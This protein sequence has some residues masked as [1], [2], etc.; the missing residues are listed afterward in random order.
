MHCLSKYGQMLSIMCTILLKLS[1][2]AT[3]I[4]KLSSTIQATVASSSISWC[5]T[6]GVL[7]WLHHDVLQTVFSCYHNLCWVA[8]WYWS[9]YFMNKMNISSNLKSYYCSLLLFQSAYILQ[10]IFY[11]Y[12]FGGKYYIASA[13]L[14]LNN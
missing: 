14:K 6:L 11:H 7:F 3:L 13:I 8:V 1:F 5:L 10:K 4:C 9:F 12:T 2:E